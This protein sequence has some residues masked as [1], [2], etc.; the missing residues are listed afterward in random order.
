VDGGEVFYALN[1]VRVDVIVET[2]GVLN[3]CC[4][5]CPGY[6]KFLSFLRSVSG[7]DAP[8]R[9]CCDLSIPR[10]FLLSS[11]PSFH[12]RPQPEV[13]SMVAYV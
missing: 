7:R 5:Q 4:G 3:K 11:I 12:C 13:H 9:S 1:A 2:F 10:P 6:D 8:N